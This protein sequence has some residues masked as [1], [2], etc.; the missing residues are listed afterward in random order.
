MKQLTRDIMSVEKAIAI[1]KEVAKARIKW[2]K[3][4]SP[5]YTV[6]Q[7]M[8]AIAALANAGL[9]EAKPAEEGPS[10]EE[11]TKLRRQLAA[12]TNREKAHKGSVILPDN[13]G[14]INIPHDADVHNG[15][16]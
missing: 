15:V 9:L 2:G 3:L 1:T 11:V 7:I 10:P 4:A 13:G 14:A 8:D 12:C 16:G 6:P 5:P